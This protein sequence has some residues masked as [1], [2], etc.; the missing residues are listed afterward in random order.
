M[1]GMQCY[2]YRT[3]NGTRVMASHAEAFAV[4]RAANDQNP[5]FLLQ[6]AVLS[7]VTQDGTDLTARQLGVF[8]T[9]HLDEGPHTVRGLAARLNVCKPAI[10]RALDKLGELGLARR[11]I[12]PQDRRS[13]V[14][15]PTDL[16]WRFL[17]ELQR[18]MGQ[19]AAG[20]A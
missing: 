1:N 8:L 12:D 4:R 13:V 20:A 16:G 3:V 18:A 9:V 7:L 15:R 14:V 11:E 2:A 19:A 6:K 17:G 10:T 5:T